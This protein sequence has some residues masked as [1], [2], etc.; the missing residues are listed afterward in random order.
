MSIQFKI[1]SFIL[2]LETKEFLYRNESN[3]KSNVQIIL[4]CI[5]LNVIIELAHS[6]LIFAQPTLLS[7]LE[8]FEK[9]MRDSN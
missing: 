1:F 2:I 4:C 7:Y 6:L 8:L 3:V 9:L 5:V